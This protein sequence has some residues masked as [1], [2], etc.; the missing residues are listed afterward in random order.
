MWHQTSFTQLQQTH[1]TTTSVK[2]ANKRTFILMTSWRLCLFSGS[3]NFSIFKFLVKQ[4][5]E[6]WVNEQIRPSKL[7]KHENTRYYQYMATTSVEVMSQHA[8][9]HTRDF[10]KRL[11]WNMIVL[12]TEGQRLRDSSQKGTRG[13]CG[14]RGHRV[15]S[16]GW[17]QSAAISTGLQ[18]SHLCGRT[19]LSTCSQHDSESLTLWSVNSDRQQEC[20][21]LL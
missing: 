1:N 11:G 7:V 14:Q 9:N 13:S 20:V 4:I 17:N 6:M 8:Y 5:H 15:S 21:L 18:V 16:S 19:P 12:V 2:K 10:I 3:C